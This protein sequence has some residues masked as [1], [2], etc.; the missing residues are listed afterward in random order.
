M[1]TEIYVHFIHIIQAPGAIKAKVG[2]TKF[3][4][5]VVDLDLIMFF[6]VTVTCNTC[7][8][9]IFP[10]HDIFFVLLLK[11]I[12]LIGYNEKN[13]VCLEMPAFEGK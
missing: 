12:R 9:P 2:F 4:N 7:V 8:I 3:C 10:E 1:N 13:L 6:P 11:S 5:P